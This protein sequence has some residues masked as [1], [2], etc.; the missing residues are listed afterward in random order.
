MWST[1]IETKSIAFLRYEY[2]QQV[3]EP[4]PCISNEEIA[5]WNSYDSAGGEGGLLVTQHC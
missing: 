3:A 2:P 5:V 1:W 4:L